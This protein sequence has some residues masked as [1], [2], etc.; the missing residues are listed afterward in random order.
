MSTTHPPEH[1]SERELALKEITSL[2]QQMKE[3]NLHPYSQSAFRRDRIIGWA[4]L[5][6]IIASLGGLIWWN[7]LRAQDLRDNLYNSCIQSNRE[8]ISQQQVYRDVAAL[9]EE[10]PIKVR[11][12]QAANGLTPRDCE[13]LY[14]K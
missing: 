3:A 2:A 10:G 1:P 6:V 13:A 5:A 12:L 11:L 8:R 4:I 14:Q 7:L 9:T